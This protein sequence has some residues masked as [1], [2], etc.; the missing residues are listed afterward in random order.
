[1]EKHYKHQFEKSPAKKGTCPQC[2]KQGQFRFYVDLPREYGKCERVNNCGYHKKP[3]G[4]FSMPDSL[5]IQKK[6]ALIIYPKVE[7][8]NNSIADQSSNFHLFCKEKLGITADHLIK[9]NTGSRLNYSTVI[10]TTFVYQDREKRFLNIRYVEYNNNCKRN[11][12]KAPYSLKAKEG[13]KYSTCLFGEQLLSEDKIICIVESEKTALIASFFY[14]AF[15]WLATGGKS[16]LTDEKIPVLYQREIY[17]LCDADAAG[18]NNSSI[19][20]LSAHQINFK[21]INLFPDKKD[22]YDLADAIIDGLLPEIKPDRIIENETEVK[23]VEENDANEA[24][25]L[26]KTGT[27]KISTFERVEKFLTK[28][29]EIRYNIVANEI[30]YREKQQTKNEFK[31]LNE[32][33]IYRLLQYKHIHFSLSN[34]SALMRS[35]FVPRFHPFWDY[36]EQLP[37]P[38]ETTHEDYIGKLCSYISAKEQERFNLHFKKMLVRS[39]ACALI[40]QVFNKHAFVLVHDKQGSGKTSFLRWLCPPALHKY[41][42]ETFIIGKDGEMSLS[43]NFIINLDELSKFGKQDIDVLKSTFSRQTI[44]QRRPY[45]RTASTMPRRANFV[46]TTNR[47]EFLTDETGSVRWLCFEI[48]GINWDYKKEVDIDKVWAQAYTLFKAGFQYELSREEIIENEKANK[49]YQVSTL[50]MELIQKN[51]IPATKEKHSVFYTASDIQ[52]D[53]AKKYP[54]HPKL[55]TTTIG[56]ALKILGFTR[57]QRSN[58]KYQEKGYYIDFFNP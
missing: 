37:A 49:D 27:K 35:D 36:F 17:Y 46:G 42:T 47:T 10:E 34:I 16:G 48:T 5:P 50:E 20:K 6:E 44:R 18:N 43:D 58:G 38:D 13:T 33:N 11:K 9:W 45:E 30:E 57:D 14:P 19:D 32:N 41:F 54:E 25:P 8:C 23:A 28:H 53:L 39:I 3:D 56:K 26:K 7:V 2:N 52:G 1:M 40:D 31:Q 22:G 51:Y 15:D 4:N 21:K 29:F 12:N 55:N 24:K